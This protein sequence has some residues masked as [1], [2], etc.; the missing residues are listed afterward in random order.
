M[1]KEE[2]AK[3][4]FDHPDSLDTALLVQQ[5]RELKKGNTVQV[6][7]YDFST[8]SRTKITDEKQPRKIIL[9]EGILIFTDQDLVDELDMK[10]YVVCG[11]SLNVS[12]LCLV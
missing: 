5:I 1:T 9:V 3:T 7:T 10:V 12:Y 4:N 11:R 2:R 8:H 6:P